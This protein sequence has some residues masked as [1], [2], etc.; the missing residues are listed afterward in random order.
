MKVYRTMLNVGMAKYVIYYHDGIKT[1]ADG[2]QFFDIDILKTKKEF[3]ERIEQLEREGY[4]Y[5][6]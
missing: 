3:I 6:N 1:H 5:N 4:T 2:S